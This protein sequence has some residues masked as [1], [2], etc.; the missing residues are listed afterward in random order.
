MIDM[1]KISNI[2]NIALSIMAVLLFSFFISCSKEQDT[3]IQQPEE[4]YIQPCITW[5]ISK[6][7]LKEK[8][9]KEFS[10]QK[11]ESEYLYYVKGN[12][13][14]T[15]TYEFQDG[16]LC[17]SLIM[18]PSTLLSTSTFNSIFEEYID[19][20]EINGKSVYINE[21]KNTIATSSIVTNSNN[22]YYAIGW[23]Q[24]DLQEIFEAIDLG[25]SVKWASCNVGATS[26]EEIG[27]YY[28]WGE[29]AE[30]DEYGGSNYLYYD[31]DAGCN[32]NIG[33]SITGTKYDVAHIKY[34]GNWRMPTSSEYEEL[35]SQCSWEWKTINDI[36]GYE[37]KGSN[38][39]VIFLPVGGYWHISDIINSN[40]GGYWSGTAIN[41]KY[42]NAAAYTL[43]FGSSYK[44]I[45]AYMREY[46]LLVRPVCN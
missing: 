38:G 35:M 46:G 18:I 1:R 29:V 34:G 43:S 21:K 44:N 30:K 2:Q 45:T 33:S 42:Y 31:E 16:V 3:P 20:G 23:T 4:T 22:S 25:L 37:I 24:L 13:G 12:L 14:T 36:Y 41:D 9:T 15:Y 27:S 10:L 8:K 40:Y 19:L 5:G 7:D 39:N 6:S 32:Q 17:T 28:A 26:P 11:E